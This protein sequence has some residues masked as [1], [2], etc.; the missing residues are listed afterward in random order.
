[1]SKALLTVGNDKVISALNFDLE[2]PAGASSNI[3]YR[4]CE[5]A[6]AHPVW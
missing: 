6:K 1:M 2:D 3:P 5:K 4:R